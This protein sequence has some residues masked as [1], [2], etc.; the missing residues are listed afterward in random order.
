MVLTYA[1][2]EN[3]TKFGSPF[4]NSPILFFGAETVTS[5]ASHSQTRKHV[6]ATNTIRLATFL[7]VRA[8]QVI[9]KLGLAASFSFILRDA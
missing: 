4:F 1:L 2:E 8:V 7:P 6:E 9:E 5:V 3:I